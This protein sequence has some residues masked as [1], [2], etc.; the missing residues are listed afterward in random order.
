MACDEATLSVLPL[1]SAVPV[2]DA[3]VAGAGASAAGGS[4]ASGAA[5]TAGTSGQGG[6]AG[7][8]AGAPG[9]V[10]HWPLDGDASDPLGM[11][12]GTLQG[13]AALVSDPVRGQALECNGTDASML[14]ENRTSN[15]FSYALWIWTE[16]P[17]SQGG[18]TLEGDA[19]LYANTTGEID[20]FTLAVLNDKLSYLSYNEV[21]TGTLSVVDGVWHHVAVTRRDGERVA[22]FLD[23]EVDG[24][25][26]AGT[27]PVS[28]NAMLHV[29][30]NPTD[31]R[32]FQGRIDDVRQFDRVLT[33]DEVRSL[34][35]E[36][37][38]P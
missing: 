14:L 30:T 2:G 36:T 5:A 12:H 11:N 26:N 13:G 31:S 37:R 19:L 35:V 8:A 25:G 21:S 34:Y 18:G 28:D 24:D 20:D 33:A 10:G 23:G 6:I 3:G 15:D 32:Y 16:T 9:M 17:S 22:L 1:G 38:L 7:G 27:G 29:C 4:D